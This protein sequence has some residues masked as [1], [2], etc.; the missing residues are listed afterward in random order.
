MKFDRYLIVVMVI[1]EL[2]FTGAALAQQ[3]APKGSQELLADLRGLHLPDNPAWWPPAPGW[4]LVFALVCV[5][6]G[7]LYRMLAKPRNKQAGYWKHNAL[8]QHDSLVAALQNGES[9]TAVL[10]QSSVLMRQIALASLP[11]E[12]AASVQDEAW[13][14]LLDKLGGTN[15]YSD[16]VGRLL[17][18]HP[19]Q[20]E[21][22]TSRE[23]VGDLL[24]LLRQTIAN[25]SGSRNV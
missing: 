20:R 11:R 24:A 1:S 2:L 3:E 9:V 16:G 13:L 6:V 10:A 19:Y 17:L 25:T 23:Q 18:T 14:Q 15:Q 5:A 22:D 21:S 4:W 7:L 12:Q 8:K